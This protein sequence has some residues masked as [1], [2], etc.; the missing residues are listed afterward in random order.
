M[1]KED[2]L[3][4]GGLGLLALI[5]LARRGE[6][7][8]KP[9]ARV[10]VAKRVAKKAGLGPGE[11]LTPSEVTAIQ[12]QMYKVPSWLQT[13]TPAPF[14][15][16]VGK[17]PAVPVIVPLKKGE[18]Q[19]AIVP[20]ANV[21]RYLTLVSSVT[22]GKPTYQQLVRQGAAPPTPSQQILQQLYVKTKLPPSITPPNIVTQRGI[23]TQA[24]SPI[25][26]IAV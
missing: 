10:V 2:I 24:K 7:K 8:A 13:A 15:V 26:I 11:E 16:K 14:I 6:A 20:V 5:T 22:V 23:A 25:S 18:A 3:I 21:R 9:G 12:G 17:T 19:L 4:L 1:R